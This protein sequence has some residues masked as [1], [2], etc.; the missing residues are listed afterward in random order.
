MGTKDNTLAVDRGACGGPRPF[1]TKRH[2]GKKKGT[3]SPVKERAVCA[4]VWNGGAARLKAAGETRRSPGARAGWAA[5]W[6]RPK[7]P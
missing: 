6:A 2:R 4:L 1:K 7:I 3:G 5:R